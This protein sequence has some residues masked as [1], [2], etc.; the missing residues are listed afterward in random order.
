MSSTRRVKESTVEDQSRF[1]VGF[2]FDNLNSYREGDWLNLR[3]EL[4]EFLD[5]GFLRHS[6]FYPMTPPKDMTEKQLRNLQNEMREVLEF[7][8]EKESGSGVRE[9]RPIRIKLD[10]TVT[11]KGFSAMG[12]VRDCTLAQLMEILKC[13]DTKPVM[14]CPQCQKIFYRKRKQLFCSTTC[15]NREMAQRKRRRDAE[16]QKKSRRKGGTRGKARRQ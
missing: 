8:V 11:P 16:T 4:Q 14:R 6:S 12:S 13:S 5:Y 15:T 2:A 1:A 3:A 10:Y 7:F 9:G